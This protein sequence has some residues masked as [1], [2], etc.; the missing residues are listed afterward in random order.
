MVAELALART[1]AVL[2]GGGQLST[3]A[4]VHVAGH[5]AAAAASGLA[6]AS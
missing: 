6:K 1:A 2:D 5:A 4:G 3:A